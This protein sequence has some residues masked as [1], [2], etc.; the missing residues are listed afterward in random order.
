MAKPKTLEEAVKM[1]DELRSEVDGN[2]RRIA[3]LEED[4]VRL[5]NEADDVSDVLRAA[6][7]VIVE[8]NRP[9][10][11]INSI[12]LPDTT[13]SRRALRALADAVS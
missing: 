11:E 13:A 8:T 3:I 2:E 12:T 9:V 6:G 5:T 10:G 4:I 1:I 7:D